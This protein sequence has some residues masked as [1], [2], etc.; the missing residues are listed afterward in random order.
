MLPGRLPVVDR[1]A[2]RRQLVTDEGLELSAYQDSLGY[3]TI[4]VGRLIDARKGGRITVAE[5]MMLLDHD[6][7]RVEAEVRA[8][9]PWFEALDAARQDVMLNMAFNLGVAGLAG[10][11]TTLGH[12]EAG[13]YAEAA[14]AMLR[15]RWA[16]QVHDRADRLAAVM[17]G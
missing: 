5:A 9:W 14:D 7:A 10:F 16:S 17:R 11:K 2:L 12:I 8:R 4:G 13:R 6:I 3:W 15:S 1:E